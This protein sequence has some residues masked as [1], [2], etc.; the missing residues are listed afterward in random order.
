VGATI[1]LRKGDM[2][3][4]PT[5]KA[6]AL[7]LE[8]AKLKFAIAKLRHQRFGQSGARR[9]IVRSLNAGFQKSSGGP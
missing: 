5:A 6:H 9:P 2:F 3:A 1:Q 8:I 4:Q 7:A